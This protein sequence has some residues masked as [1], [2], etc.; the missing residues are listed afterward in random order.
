M[1]NRIRIGFTLG[2]VNGIGP[3][4]VIK[5]LEDKRMLGLCTP[6]I[7]GSNRIISFYKKLFNLEGLSYTTINSADQA[8]AKAVNIINCITQEVMI[9][10]GQENETGARV[11]LTS[12]EAA[13][14]DLLKGQLD[15]IVTA[16]I[17]KHNLQ[18]IGFNYPGHTEY[19]NAKAP[20]SESVMLLMQGDLR[21][22]LATGH[23][24][25]KD[26]ASALTKEGLL[27]KLEIIHHSLKQDFAS[28]GP[29]IAVLGLN[30]HAGDSG[31]LG[32]EESNIII[33]AIKAAQE[34]KMFVTGPFSADGFFGSGQYQHFDAILAMYHDQ[35][36]VGFKSL[37]FG[38]G[39]NYT[40][41]LPFVRTSPDHGTAFDI[42]G[43]NE[44]SA[45]S[46][47]Q[48]IFTAVDIVRSRKVY[49]EI[50]ANP[51]KRTEVASERGA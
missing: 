18:S 2:D 40:A 12:L 20:E 38:G 23:I 22:G 1:E 3:E 39:V 27:R 44:A 10:P 6:V 9:M 35:G 7:Y 28:T 33:P 16:P 29:R 26:V 43:K 15:A 50:T 30:P 47:L 45:E 19:F 36:L 48:A 8:N 37:S 31:T 11:A 49:H 14:N 21:V 34:K 41:G 13:T 17:N 4:V 42:A 51:L 32:A 46:M 24:P 25:V 5:A